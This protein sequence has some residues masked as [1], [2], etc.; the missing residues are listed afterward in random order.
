MKK[1]LIGFLIGIMLTGALFAGPLSVIPA[2]AQAG[3]SGWAEVLPGIVS[4]YRESLISPLQAAGEEIQDSG[5]SRFYQRLLQGYELNKPSPEVAGAELS[6]LAELLPDIKNIN[7][8]AVTLPLQ[9]AGANIQDE[10]IARFYH[11]F[12]KSAGWEIETE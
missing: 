2:R 8:V 6:G 3:D 12:L 11:Q 7:Y 5:T 4:A 9:E 1:C 10:E